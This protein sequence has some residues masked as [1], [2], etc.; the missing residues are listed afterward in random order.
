MRVSQGAFTVL[1]GPNGAGKTTLFNLV[2]ALFNPDEGQVRIN[3]IH[4]GQHPVRALAHLGVVF[5]QQT[6]DMTLSVRQNLE[7]HA[8]LQG[9][10]AAE[11]RQ[12]I[13]EECERLEISAMLEDK[14]RTLN[15][16]HRR[17]VEIARALLHNPPLLLLDEPTA[18][19]DLV[20]RQGLHAHIL[21]LCRE[22]GMAVLW[23]T[24]LLEEI[25]SGETIHVLHQ[26]RIVFEG[27]AEEML[28]ITG[29]ETPTEAFKALTTTGGPQ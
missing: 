21:S 1:L 23:A 16:G 4:V 15:G 6:L 10:S 29:K 13:G 14:V 3:G 20:T 22:R 18:G 8:S 24:H 26:G 25:Q 7:F 9:M 11:T 2:T 17:R 27:D 19:L 12:R 5:Q 28:R